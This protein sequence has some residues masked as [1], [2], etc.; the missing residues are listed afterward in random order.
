MADEVRQGDFDDI[1]SGFTRGKGSETPWVCL[2]CGAVVGQSADGADTYRQLH[3]MW[4]KKA[5]GGT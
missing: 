4:H 3:L 1:H 5:A 2:R